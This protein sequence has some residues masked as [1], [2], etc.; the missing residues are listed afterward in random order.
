MATAPEPDVTAEFGGERNVAQLRKT[1]RDFRSTPGVVRADT[2]RH[3]DDA[4][5]R[6]AA[7]G[8]DGDPRR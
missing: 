3:A 8:G 4:D 7:R 1:S 2:R 5:R 6:A